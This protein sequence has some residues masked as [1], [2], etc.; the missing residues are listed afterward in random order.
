M[1]VCSISGVRIETAMKY[2]V[3]IE[4]DEDG[5]FVATC[6]SLPGC[7]SQGVTRDEARRNIQEAI[8]GYLESLEEHG[9]PIPPGIQE[10]V[11]EVVSK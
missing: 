9:D 1:S 6:P 8:T 10:E 4:Q 7:V 3:L 5:P 2:R 11:I